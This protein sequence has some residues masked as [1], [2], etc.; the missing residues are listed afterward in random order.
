MNAFDI[1]LHLNRCHYPVRGLGYGRRVGI[2]LQGCSIHCPGCMVP[3]TWKA[4]ARHEV[5]L[6]GLLTQ[7][8][9]WLEPCDGV[10]ISGGEPFEQPEALFALVV[11]LRALIEGDILVY[12]GLPF[13]RL[14]RN[15]QAVVN[16][17]DVVISEPFVNAL[18]ESNPILCGSS[19]QAVRL[20]T[21]LARSR[22]A[23]WQEFP[24]IMGVAPTHDG[25]D[26]AGIPRP[27][28]LALLVDRLVTPERQAALTHAE[29]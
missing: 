24:K 22:Y 17:V 8:L 9:P 4:Q 16:A 6:G 18:R 2:W 27:G 21:E 13:Q 14:L 7:L 10:T 11:A 1:Q 15:Y 12:S 28:E 25:L 3:E 5:Q 20:L 29:I 23:Q 26:L 19:N